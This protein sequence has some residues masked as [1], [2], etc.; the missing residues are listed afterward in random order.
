MRYHSVLF[1]FLFLILRTC[2]NLDHAVKFIG[3]EGGLAR[4]E[5]HNRTSSDLS[6]I[7]LE[8]TY[9]GDRRSVVRIDTVSYTAAGLDGTGTVFLKAKQSTMIVQTAPQGTTSAEGRILSVR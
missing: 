9:L 4:F 1:L 6:A 2:E 3:V 5:L 7:E 8:I